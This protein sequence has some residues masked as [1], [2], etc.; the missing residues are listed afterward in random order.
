M[1]YTVTDN[2]LTAKHLEQLDEIIIENIYF[3]WYL[4]EEK[5]V[6]ANDGH[7]HRHLIYSVDA[8]KSEF[9]TPIIDIFKIPVYQAELDLDIKKL[10]LF[11][12][13]YKENNKGRFLSNVGGYQTNDMPLDIPTTQPL[14]KEIEEHASNFAKGFINKKKQ[15][16]DN[17]WFN[18]NGYKDSNIPHNHPD[19]TIA[20]VFYVKTP[21]DCGCLIMQHPALDVLNYYDIN[22][23]IEKYNNYNA[24][25]WEFQPAVNNLY[26]FPAWVKHYVSQNM[27][28]ED[29]ISLSFNTK[30]QYK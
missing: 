3:P 20:G 6:G 21:K 16:L 9:Y 30:G 23:N 28:K 1:D 19:T 12:N 26:L 25:E 13:A 7:W 14:I 22:L 4:Q 15:S 29:R 2:L 5:V 24:S 17:M 27:N 11:C 18:I 8:P 10:E